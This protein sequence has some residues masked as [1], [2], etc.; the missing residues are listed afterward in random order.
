LE[1]TL[2]GPDG[3]VIKTAII[4]ISDMNSFSSRTFFC[5]EVFGAENFIHD[6]FVSVKVEHNSV[7]PRLV[8][9]NY[10]KSEN[11]FEVT[12]SYP[13]ISQND[14]C[15]NDGGA[16]FQSLICGF[17]SRDLGLSMRSFPTFCEN[18]MSF[19]VFKK[20]FGQKALQQSHQQELLENVREFISGGGTLSLGGRDEFLAIGLRGEKVPTRMTM[21]YQF[22][23]KHTESPFSTD[24]S[25]GAK[26]SLFPPKHFFWGH[27][28]IGGN[29]DTCIFLRNK[30]HNPRE[31]EASTGTLTVH[32]DEFEESYEIDI[33]SETMKPIQINDLLRSRGLKLF[34][35]IKFVSWSLIMDQATCDT[36]WIGYDKVSGNIFG[37][38]GF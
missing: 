28:A 34:N 5:D 21:S 30:S 2:R 26:A 8:V 16:D 24:I 4:D 6:A 38:H 33:G 11:F 12:H 32:G 17:S 36:F 14:Y 37:D 18:E 9:G 1:A 25:D 15:P 13:Y 10:F 29:F 23:V 3:G 35:E 19:D 20:T 27:G 31:T 22:S 7:Y